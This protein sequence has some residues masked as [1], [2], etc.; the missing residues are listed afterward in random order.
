VEHPGGDRQAAAE[1]EII[2]NPQWPLTDEL[3]L[4]IAVSADWGHRY[5]QRA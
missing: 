4:S 2:V 3:V 1:V 5:F